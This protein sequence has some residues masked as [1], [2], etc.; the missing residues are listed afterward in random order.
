MG[1]ATAFADAATAVPEDALSTAIER[2]PGGRTFPAASTVG[3][4]LRE[5]EIHHADLAAG[6]THREWPLEFS[7]PARSTRW[8]SGAPRRDP[9]QVAPTDIDR[10]WSFGE[11]GPTVS[12][13][14]ADLAWW[15]TGRRPA[16]GLTSDNGVLPGIEAW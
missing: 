4:R 7:A 13:P 15:L 14:A 9:F 10:T 2:T 1:G 5:V 11:G 6:Y 16:D 3:M 8:S 12:G